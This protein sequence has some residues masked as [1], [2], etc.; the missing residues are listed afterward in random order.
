M[1]A[2]L[3][4]YSHRFIPLGEWNHVK[5]QRMWI[6]YVENPERGPVWSIPL[7]FLKSFRETAD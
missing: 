1:K 2:T 7:C 5:E 4:F 6:R 3:S